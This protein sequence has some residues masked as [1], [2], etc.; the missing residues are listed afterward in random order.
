MNGVGFR[1]GEIP[2]SLPPGPSEADIR[3][4]LER[5]ETSGEFDV[6]DRLRAFLRYVVGEALAG[7]AD[8]I[9]A[10]TIALEVFGRDADFDTRNDPIVRI[11]AGRLRRALE[12]YYLVAG[13]ADPVLIEIPKGRYVPAFAVN[14][15]ASETAPLEPAATPAPNSADVAES[16]PTPWRPRTLVAVAAAVLLLGMGWWFAGP[17]TFR[18]W[19]SAPIAAS[20]PAGPL[21]LVRPLVNLGGD[22]DAGIYAAG[23]TDEV[24]SQL[25]RFKELRVM[26]RE[27]SSA[28][29]ATTGLSEIR[30]D[31]G[32]RYVLEGTVKTGGAILRVNV[33]LLD[34]E[35]SVVLW[36]QTYE[37][38]LT[39]RDI[40]GVVVDMA[41]QVAATVAQPYGI[42][43]STDGRRPIAE[44]PDDIAAYGCTLQFYQYRAVLGREEHAAVRACLERTVA[45][46]PGYGT[47]WA[48]LSY[49]YLDE[50]R[51]EFNPR[52]GP[53]SGGTTAIQ[54]ALDAA[55]RA[56]RVEP[57]NMR[58]LQAMMTALYFSGEPKEALR[59]GEQALALN[60]NDTEFLGEFGSR[61]AQAGDWHRGSELLEQALAMNP[62][63]S[64]YYS[65]FLALCA[66]MLGDTA[67]AVPLIREADL[68]KFPLFHVVA[69]LI[70]ADAG[71]EKEAAESRIQ[72]LKMRPHF[73][74]DLDAELDK[75][76]FGH[77]DQ[78]FL[79]Q[80]ARKAGFPVP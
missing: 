63:N 56:V 61:V 43:F 10:Y 21:L 68:G 79:A 29:S 20:A 30:T 19:R 33:R 3:A 74:D 70:F 45:E 11:E 25:A 58:A 37:A 53:E 28:L 40:L 18:L 69:A 6:P 38:D 7:R 44:A 5:I 4:Q 42:I 52:S 75:R 32:V 54:R 51:F 46:F 2:E 49:L 8:R 47:A 22:E 9:K 77:E 64:G 78:E 73:F 35:S 55:R 80:A 41:G 36:A 16:R 26:G 76:N 67:R 12:R 50:D 57:Y 27:T 24:L 65:G 59:V 66:F 71:L 34:S 14:V 13:R 23:L 48:M 62:G 1:R 39:S 17:D 31:L 15:P 60:P 72:F